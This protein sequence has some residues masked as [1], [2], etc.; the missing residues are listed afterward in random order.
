MNTDRQT[1]GQRQ[2][3]RQVRMLQF[4]RWVLLHKFHLHPSHLSDTRDGSPSPERGEGEGGG[5][6]E[7]GGVKRGRRTRVDQASRPPSAGISFCQ[8]YEGVRCGVVYV[9]GIYCEAK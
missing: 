9:C 2:T 7:R 4:F 8:D 6:K 1:D 5:G 3:D